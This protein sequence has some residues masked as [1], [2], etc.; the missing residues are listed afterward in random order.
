MFET[1]ITAFLAIGSVVAAA[2]L[3]YQGQA[4]AGAAKKAKAVELLAKLA[5]PALPDALN[6]FI[7]VVAPVLIDFLVSI[8]SKT[9]FFTRLFAALGLASNS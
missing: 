1:I 3:E 6:P 9:G 5:D 2:E 8:M 7:L 4:Q